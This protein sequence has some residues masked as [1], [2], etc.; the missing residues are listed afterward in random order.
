MDEST[1]GTVCFNMRCNE[2]TRPVTQSFSIMVSHPGAKWGVVTE[3]RACHAHAQSSLAYT[4]TCHKTL[5]NTFF[6]QPNESAEACAI[7]QTNFT[8]YFR[9]HHCRRCGDVVCASHLTRT[10]PL[11]Q[12]ARYNPYGV[13]SKSCDSCFTA[14]R[15]IK[16]LRHSRTSSLASSM[17]SSFSAGT[18]KPGML[19]PQQAKNDPSM[20][21]GSMARSEGGMV[22]STF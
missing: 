10:V 15:T 18:A 3:A 4:Q 7:C 17:N 14:W 20:F 2:S 1:R 8:W 16:K 9:K 6:L 11:D 22:W 21:V 13:E 5:T 19:I 12:N